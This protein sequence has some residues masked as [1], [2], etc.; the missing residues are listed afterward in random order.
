M[1]KRVLSI[2]IDESGDLGVYNEVTEFYVI[3]FVF[4]D[5]SNSIN[6]QVEKLSN[7]MKIYSS[8]AFAIHTEPLIR[9]EEIYRDMPPKIRRDIFTKLY[10]F[11][12]SANVSFKVFVFNKKHL[13]TKA[14]LLE[15]IKRD[16]FEYF[17]SH[18]YLFDKFDEVVIYYDNGQLP[19][20][21][22]VH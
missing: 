13:K 14:V 11:S 22:S 10:F 19:L 20:K 21:Q 12:L 16:V 9:R 17:Y 8:E 3:S 5:Q 2:F 18:K 6:G 1:E 4:H 7:S 15:H